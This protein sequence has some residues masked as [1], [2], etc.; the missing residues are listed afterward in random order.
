MVQSSHIVSLLAHFLLILFVVYVG[1]VSN[2]ESEERHLSPSIQSPKD[3]QSDDETDLRYTTKYS[4]DNVKQMLRVEIP[5]ASERLK[6][7]SE[8]NRPIGFNSKEQRMSRGI[9]RLMASGECST[10]KEAIETLERQFKKES[11]QNAR[12]STEKRRKINN[13]IDKRKRPGIGYGEAWMTKR[14]KSLLKKEGNDI[15]TPKEAL[16]M[17]SK[18]WEEIKKKSRDRKRLKLRK[19]KLEAP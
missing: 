13:Y 4:R 1:C 2:D 14:M 5:T 10:R 7:D 17:A 11:K 16:K 8:G 15:H 6:R 12:N 3:G 9:D 19:A 18:Q